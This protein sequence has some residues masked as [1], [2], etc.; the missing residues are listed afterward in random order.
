MIL[1]NIVEALSAS[2]YNNKVILIMISVVIIVLTVD[3]SLIKISDLN[4]RVS[5]SSSMIS[6]F[7]VMLSTYVTAQYIIMEFIKRK[8]NRTDAKNTPHFNTMHKIV[9]IVQYFQ[10]AILAFVVLQIVVMSYYNVAMII[11]ATAISYTL[12]VAL[13]GLLAKRFFSWFKSYKNFVVLL[14]GLTSAILAINAGF[15]LIFVNY[16]LLSKPTVVVQSYMSSNPPFF[17]SGSI[18][19]KLN[20][21]Y[22]ISSILSFMITWVATAMLLRHYSPRLGIVKYWIILSIP[23]V[24][25]LSQFLSLFLNLFAS[26]LKSDPVFF[27]IIFTL[28]F[29]LSR[30]AGGMLFG[31]AFWAIARNIHHNDAVR[32]YLTISAYGFVLLF[33]SNQAIVLVDAPYPPFGLATISFMGLSAYLILVGISSSAI[34]IAEDSKLRQSIRKFA[35]DESKLLDSIGSAQMEQQIEKKVIKMTKEHQDSMTEETGIQSSLT[36]DDMKQYLEMVLKEVKTKRE[37][38]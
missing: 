37:E 12:A 21:A 15:T 27:G 18:T 16:V 8:S 31:L 24:Y 2:R 26:L 20:Y 29:T 34:S 7:I 9:T 25:F 1:N 35:I 32:D 33:I 6:V 5:P 19:D 14:Y 17:V 3:I 4:T 13:L 23:L 30:P 11:A 38:G 36:E 22:V 28:I 10:I